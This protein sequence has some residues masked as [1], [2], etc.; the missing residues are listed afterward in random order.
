MKDTSQ[1]L[2]EAMLEFKQFE[3]VYN[4]KK[5]KVAELKDKLMS[6]MLEEGTLTYKAEDITASISTSVVPTVTDWGLLYNYIRENN[7]FDLL[8][9]RISATAW[10]DRK[11]EEGSIAGTDETEIKTLRV[12]L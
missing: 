6:E 9:K 12:K 7:A 8:Q 2:K 3:K 4:S 1:E 10:R 11:E 5:K